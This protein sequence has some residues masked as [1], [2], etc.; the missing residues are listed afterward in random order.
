M[1]DEEV[2]EIAEHGEVIFREVPREDDQLEEI[3][4]ALKDLSPRFLLIAQLPNGEVS[5]SSLGDVRALIEGYVLAR[6]PTLIELLGV[7]TKVTDAAIVQAPPTGIGEDVFTLVAEDI[8]AEVGRGALWGLDGHDQ[9]P[10]VQLAQ[11]IIDDLQA[12]LELGV[13]K[14]GVRLQTNNGRN[15]LLDAYQEALD[16]IMYLRQRIAET[17]N[18]AFSHAERS[19]LMMSYMSA[20]SQVAA[21]CA[22]VR[23]ERLS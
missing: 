20:I 16:L 23:E 18:V 4:E 8:K 21:L 10:N 14:Y 22:Q 17:E 2:E 1:K 9:P 19:K 15:A 7:P 11:Q 6:E 12:R 13:K 5:A 3:L